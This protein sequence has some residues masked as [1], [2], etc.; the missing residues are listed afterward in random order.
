MSGPKAN[1]GGEAEPVTSSAGA[2]SP[3]LQPGFILAAGRLTVREICVL[4]AERSGA[5]GISADGFWTSEEVGW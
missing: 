2:S 3:T 4:A 1:T 5:T